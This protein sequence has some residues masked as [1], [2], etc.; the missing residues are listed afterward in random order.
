MYFGGLFARGSQFYE[1][2]EK[3]MRYLTFL[4][5]LNKSVISFKVWSPPLVISSVGN[6]A[7]FTCTHNQSEELM[8]ITWRRH[9]NS[10]GDQKILDYSPNTSN[11]KRVQQYILANR[12]TFSEPPI[13]D[14]QK[15][16]SLTVANLD[17]LDEGKYECDIRLFPKPT[18]GN[19]FSRLTVQV[20]PSKPTLEATWIQ[21]KVIKLICRSQFGKPAAQLAWYYNQ[22]ELLDSDSRLTTYNTNSVG[23]GSCNVTTTVSELALEFG[24]LLDEITCESRHPAFQKSESTR[25]RLDEQFYPPKNTPLNIA[26]LSDG[27]FKLNCSKNSRPPSTYRWYRMENG[28][29]TLVS[30]EAT[31]I[32]DS[33]SDMAVYQCV[34][35]YPLSVV[36]I[37]VHQNWTLGGSKNIVTLATTTHG[38][39]AGAVIGVTLGI[40][41]LLVLATIAFFIIKRKVEEENEAHLEASK[42][43]VVSNVYAGSDVERSITDLDAHSLTEGSVRYSTHLQGYI[44]DSDYVIPDPD[45]IHSGSSKTSISGSAN[46]IGVFI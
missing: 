24:S 16:T 36:R 17:C 31:L 43:G 44:N 8:L 27:N 40:L 34:V 29:R 15:E 21:E 35:D 46:P 39:D 12:V 9:S 41:L 30:R 42:D 14:G 3:L 7:V 19:A 33:P 22:V 38:T 4:I 11:A 1:K 6:S 32:V 26:Q 28:T 5:T 13:V 10:Y 18:D 20:A 25:M 23:R 37:T 2:M 45:P